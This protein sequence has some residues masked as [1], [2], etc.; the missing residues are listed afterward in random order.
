[1]RPDH[2][3]PREDSSQSPHPSPAHAL[4]PGNKGAHPEIDKDKVREKLH[5]LQENRRRLEELRAGAP[6]A[7]GRTPSPRRPPRA[8]CKYRSRP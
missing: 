2:P 7:S 5:F 1:M 4:Q 3:P 8:C 6:T